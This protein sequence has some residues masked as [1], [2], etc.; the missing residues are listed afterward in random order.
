[1]KL[2]KSPITL[3]LAGFLS[4]GVASGINA[5]KSQPAPTVVG[6]AM[7]NEVFST[8]VTAVKAAD[9]VTTLNGEGPFTVFAPT[10]DAFGK[11]ADGTVETLL[12]PENKPSLAGILTY[13]VV[14]GEF[15]AADV[16]SAIKANDNAFE[17]ETVQG[18]SLTLSL[19]DGA[20]I[21]TDVNGNSSKVTATD[22]RA[23]NGVIHVIDTVVLPE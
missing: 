12:K 11:L 17:V 5:Q 1:M 21:L 14:A 13:H 3:F 7:D 15:M 16:V 2:F 8:L 6:I 19:L 18:S 23:S 22:V 10:N 9:L 4:L 20:V